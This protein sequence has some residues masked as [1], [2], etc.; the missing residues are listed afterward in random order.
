[1]SHPDIWAARLLDLTAVLDALTA[2]VLAAQ[3]RMELQ[4]SEE[5]LAPVRAHVEALEEV[6]RG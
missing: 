1:M 2:R 4:H 5:A 3:T 6:F